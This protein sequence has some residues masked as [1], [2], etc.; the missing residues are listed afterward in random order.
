MFEAADLN[1]DGYVDFNE[2]VVMRRKAE[3]RERASQEREALLYACSYA[4]C[5]LI[6]YMHAPM[7]HACE[8]ARWEA[9]DGGAR[10]RNRAEDERA[11]EHSIA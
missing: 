7:L 2:F 11:K 3:R 9:A 6:C 5:M 10:R 8:Q 1:Q 4:T